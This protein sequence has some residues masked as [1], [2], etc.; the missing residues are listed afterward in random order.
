MEESRPLTHT[1]LNCVGKADR[2]PGVRF[3]TDKK[4]H[5]FQLGRA[6]ERSAVLGNKGWVSVT[7]GGD[8]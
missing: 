6:A 2:K 5:F 3:N 8:I 1:D 7:I 4:N